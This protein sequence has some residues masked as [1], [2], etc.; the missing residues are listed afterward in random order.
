MIRFRLGVAV[1][2]VTGL[3]IGGCETGKIVERKV[4]NTPADA[5]SGFLGYFEVSTHRTTCGNCHV[6][7]QT[8]WQQTA[9]AHAYNDLEESGQAASSCYGCHTVNERGNL[10]VAPG[11]WSAVQDS[12]YWDV[13]CESCHGPGLDHV[14]NPDAVQPLASILADTGATYG[15]G[16]CHSGTHNPFVE[17]W[18]ESAH[19]Q[20]PHQA[21]AIACGASCHDGKTAL[22]EKF[23][24]TD[25]YLEKGDP[26]GLPITCA[27]CH[28]PHGSPYDHQLRAPIDVA[29]ADHLCVRCHS[30]RATPPS[31]HGPH[32]PQGLLVLGEN[33]GWIPPNFVYDTSRIV[34]THGT[35]ANPKLC[36]TCHVPAF[37]VTDAATGALVFHSVGHRF[38]AIACLG[39]DSLPTSGPCAVGQRDFRACATSGCH[40]TAISAR[41]AYTVLVQRLNNLVD[42]LWT[43][44]N[45]DHVIDATDGGLLPQVVAMGDT[46]QLNVS[47]QLVTVAE[48]A[49]WN[50]Q[51]AHTDERPE[52]GDGEVFGVHFSAQEGSGNGVH[53]PFL[54]E[55]LLTAS[56]DAVKQ[57]YGLSSPAGSDG[58][59]HATPP[60]GLRLKK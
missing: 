8:A 45:G 48:G 52:W 42:Q 46:S 55:A 36:A 32:A 57:A 29:T 41:S 1:V 37:D 16:E 54:L 50:A 28:N 7:K 3:L 20:V 31:S 27:V 53:N 14:E 34:G 2:L 56:I 6:G 60:A 19:G 5:A 40:G 33:A 51:L 17:Q 25:N 43:D 47:D 9:H 11:G 49:M 26:G 59:I 15:C 12:T 13:Q 35:Q 18:K 38:E 24:E 23:S 39:P 22:V 58:T 4:S 44:R 30:R 21:A 10:Q